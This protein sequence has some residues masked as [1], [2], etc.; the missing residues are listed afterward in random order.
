MYGSE[1]WP[2][3]LEEVR[4]LERVERM[5]RWMCA[6]TLKNRYKSEELRK[7]LD[8]EDVVKLEEREMKRGFP[9]KLILLLKDWH[10]HFF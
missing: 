6:V 4:R 3:R 2:M 10:S 9:I 8:I 7:R 1:T 5:I